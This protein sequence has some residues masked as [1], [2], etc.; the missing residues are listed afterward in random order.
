MTLLETF[1]ADIL[2]VICLCELISNQEA[3]HSNFKHSWDPN[4]GLVR[5]SNVPKLSST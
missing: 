5:Y 1:F 4:N 3:M 2:I